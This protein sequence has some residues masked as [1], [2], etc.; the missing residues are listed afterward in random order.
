MNKRLLCNL[1]HL[2]RH[3]M[4]LYSN[5]TKS[6]YDRIVYSVASMSLQRIGIPNESLISI[7][8]IIQKIEHI[9]R[10]AFGDSKSYIYG[11][12]ELKLY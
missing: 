7:F 8:I 11:R 1:A 2:M 9:V 5:D 4:I 3:L 10:I 12:G 6:Y